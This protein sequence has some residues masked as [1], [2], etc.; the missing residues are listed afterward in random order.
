LGEAIARITLLGDAAAHPQDE[1]H[2]PGLDDSSPVGRHD[3]DIVMDQIRLFLVD[4]EHTVR[5][6]LR[7]RLGM[8]PDFLVIGEAADGGKALAG[9]ASTRP[10]V[11]LM[12]I[13]LPVIDGIQATAVLRDTVPGCAVVMLSMQDDADTRSRARQA[14]AVGFVAK[15]E[16]ESALAAAIRAAAQRAPHPGGG[17]D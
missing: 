14:G 9:V 15:H 12:D 3:T 6:G 8:E 11:V 1:P 2:P 17:G 7:M 4:D 5:Q 16:I 13:H 10:D